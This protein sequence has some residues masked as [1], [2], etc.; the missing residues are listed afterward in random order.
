MDPISIA[1]KFSVQGEPVSSEP[2]GHGHINR[3]YRVQTDAGLVY[4]L[5]QINKFCNMKF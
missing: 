2:F 5:Q 4:V 3:T 1:K